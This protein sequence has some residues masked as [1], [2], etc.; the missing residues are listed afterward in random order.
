MVEA[1][2]V[3]DIESEVEKPLSILP[4][5]PGKF[6]DEAR[7]WFEERNP[8]IWNVCKGSIIKACEVL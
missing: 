8:G 1:V 6:A 4:L 3:W 7:R 5:K 2:T